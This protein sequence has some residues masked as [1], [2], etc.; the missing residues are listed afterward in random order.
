[1]LTLNASSALEKQEDEGQSAS[2]P[3]K[4]FKSGR[5][6]GVRLALPRPVPSTPVTIQVGLS[7]S[8]PVLLSRFSYGQ[9]LKNIFD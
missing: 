8:E 9:L 5:M 6:D 1:M 7:G 4:P 2:P 3:E